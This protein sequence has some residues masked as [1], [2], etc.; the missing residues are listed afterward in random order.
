MKTPA[1]NLF[2]RQSQSRILL[3]CFSYLRP[4][5]RLTAGAYGM[6]VLIDLF[7]MI[8]PQLI[9]WAIDKG[10]RIGNT[11]KLTLAVAALLLLVVIKGL[12]TYFQGLW[13]EVASQSVAYDLRNEI[14]RKITLLSFSFHDQAEAGDLLSR[15]IQ[16]VERIR[17][18]TGRATFRVTEGV[19]LMAITAAVMIWMNPRL[20]LMAIVAMPLLAWQSIRFGRTFRPLSAQ[21]QKQLGV[22]TTRVEQNLR[23]ARVVKTFAQENSEIVRFEYENS[24]WFD[25]SA[26]AARLQSFNMPLLHLIANVSSVVILWYGGM[27]VINHQLTLGELVAFTTYV[28]Q[29]VAPVRFLGM[30]L[31]AIS[32]ASASAERVF[33]ILD[34]VP[35]V[36][37][38]PDAPALSVTRGHVVMENVT[39][40]YGRHSGVLRGISFEAM[41]NQVIALLGPTGSGKSTIVNLIPRFYDPTDG[42]VTIDGQD[43]RGVTINSLRSQIG[44]VLQETT[45]FAASIRENIT[46]GKP[47]AVQE[48]IEAAAR[49]A[50][51]HDFIKQTPGGYDTEVGERGVTLSGGQ[52]QRLAIA[53]AILTDPRILI[54]DDATSSVDAETEYLIQLALERVMHGRTTF[55]IA[56]RLST[57][58]RADLILVLDK[59]RIV[60]RGK[61]EELLKTSPLYLKIYEQQIKPS[62]AHAKLPS[63]P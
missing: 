43:I 57:L 37:E 11:S 21:I 22:L 16:D 44:M 49:A 60:A 10:M 53:R 5:W 35:E 40:S 56:H 34:T 47:D 50:Q 55:V 62:K 32:M 19:F 33:E 42:R 1:T 58:Q 13:T 63:L 29:L 51:A 14:Q 52:R 54:L 17:F 45:L 23:G 38:E 24:R 48:E 4:H 59:G 39:F 26:Y 15:A 18:L 25:L 8:N 7:N 36:R 41:P 61:H 12:F 2:P 28:A 3:R 30:I 20:G 27:L 9:R 31:P 6:M 46:F